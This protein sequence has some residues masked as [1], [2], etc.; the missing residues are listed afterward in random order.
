MLAPGLHSLGGSPAYRAEV[1]E[2]EFDLSR[3]MEFLQHTERQLRSEPARLAAD[4]AQQGSKRRAYRGP[5]RADLHDDRA[6]QQ[7][8]A[9]F[10]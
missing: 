6:V 7:V 4:V 10:M 8:P 3:E 2:L 1:K 5:C 9:Y